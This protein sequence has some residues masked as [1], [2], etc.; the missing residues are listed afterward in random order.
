MGMRAR[1]RVH[2]MLGL[3]FILSLAREPGSKHKHC[4]VHN[5]LTEK[6]FDQ[7]SPPTSASDSFGMHFPTWIGGMDPLFG[8]IHSRDFGWN[9]FIL[10]GYHYHSMW[11][12][13]AMGRWN[14]F[15]ISKQDYRAIETYYKNWRLRNGRRS[16][17]FLIR[18]RQDERD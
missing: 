18:E 5:K 2:W 14:G 12:A 15:L 8:S 11:T 6:K 17:S 16:H 4:C 13:F 9:V 10:L 1:A 7:F 3:P